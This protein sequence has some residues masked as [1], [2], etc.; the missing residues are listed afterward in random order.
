MQELK[1]ENQVGQLVVDGEIVNNQGIVRCLTTITG[2]NTDVN[3]M[4]VYKNNVFEL[5]HTN[6]S[7]YE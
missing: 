1:C 3:Y 6:A 4:A 7:K 2:L 5:L